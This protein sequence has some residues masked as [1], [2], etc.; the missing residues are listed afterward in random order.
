MASRSQ[1]LRQR[2]LG[3]AARWA[4]QLAVRPRAWPDLLRWIARRIK[5][6][7]LGR[8][9]VSERTR[10]EMQESTAWCADRAISLEQALA[11]LG[12]TGTPVDLHL[13]FHEELAAAEARVAS[14]PYRLG[15]ASN[16]DLIYTLCEALEARRVVET[17]VANG[18]SSLA[19]LLSIAGRPGAMLHS[20]DLPYLKYQND[21]WVGI[22]VPGSLTHC[23]TLHCMADREGLPR[24]L[25]S[26]G[27]ID[28]AHYDSD[29]SKEGRAF[30]YPLLWRALRPGGLLF[31][32]DINDNF[33]FRDFCD[34][35]G[36]VP[37]IVQ[38]DNKFQ[39]ILRKPHEP[40]S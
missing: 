31:S 29:K 25:E 20:V 21:R 7:I 22:A 36:Q 23:W 37:V 2:R 18:W 5:I 15:G 35:A 28:F 27:T 40:D 33:G 24:A 38:Q 9:E 16:M 1:L 13:H 12:I 34:V 11:V 10:R 17:G 4:A 8:D 3:L 14:V 6:A 19:I 39:G 30:A 26:L 32:D